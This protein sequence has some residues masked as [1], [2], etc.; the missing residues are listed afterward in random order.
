MYLDYLS[1]SKLQEFIQNALAEDHG[2]G[3]HTSIGSIS[4]KTAVHTQLLFKDAGIV[5]GMELAKLIFETVS[6][7]IYFEPFKKDGDPILSGEIG[8][9]VTGNARDVLAAERLV[10]NCMQRMSGI[11]TILIFSTFSSK[12]QRPNSWILAKPLRILDSLKNGPLQ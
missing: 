11:A 9:Q 2:D 4:T 1:T 8:F 7:N 3:D 10:L 5:A 12:I 6:E